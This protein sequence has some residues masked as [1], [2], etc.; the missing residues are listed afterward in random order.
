[1]GG[2]KKPDLV[3]PGETIISLRAPGSKLD[4]ELPYLRVGKGYF[5]LSGTSISTP[6][7]SGAAAQLLQSNPSLSPIQVKTILKRNAFRLRLGANTAGSG[8]INVRFL[9]N[10]MES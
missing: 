3:A 8:G 2:W 5:T 7:V 9:E 1:M 10:K 4:R 6:L